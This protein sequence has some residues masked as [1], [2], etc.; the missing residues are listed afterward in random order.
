MNTPNLGGVDKANTDQ[1]PSK[2]STSLPPLS[3]LEEDILTVLLGRELYG[4]Q[5][6]QAIKEASENRQVLKVGSLYPSLH[7]LEKKGF[8]KSRMDTSGKGLESRGGNRRKYYQITGIG[9]TALTRKQTM[10]QNLA[11]WNPAPA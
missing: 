4:L 9:A 3:A 10:R 11:G 5:I 7:R 6:C 1:S 2:K 8:V